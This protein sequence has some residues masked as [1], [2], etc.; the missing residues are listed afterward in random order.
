MGKFKKH[1]Y[2]T[3]P[4]IGLVVMLLG[5]GCASLSDDEYISELSKKTQPDSK[6]ELP[7]YVI[8]KREDMYNDHSKI[9]YSAD[10]GFA[11]LKSGNPE[12]ASEFLKKADNSIE[13][14]AKK[15]FSDFL[16]AFTVKDNSCQYVGSPFEQVQIPMY[17]SLAK[18]E[19]GDYE[20]AAAMARRTNIVVTD[21]LAKVADLYGMEVGDKKSPQ[22]EAMPWHYTR[23]AFADYIASISYRNINDT[24]N[25]L[26]A[27]RNSVDT[28]GSKVW[29][30][31]YKFT[32][33]PAAVVNNYCQLANEIDGGTVRAK[34]QQLVEKNCKSYTK[35]DKTKGEVVV[36]QFLGRPAFLRSIDFDI[37]GGAVMNT[38]I[39][40][41]ADSF[42]KA[43]SGK[44]DATK[45]QNLLVEILI[46]IYHSNPEIQRS[47]AVQ[48]AKIKADQFGNKSDKAATTA[49]AGIYSMAGAS[50][51]NALRMSV[52]IPFQYLQSLAPSKLTIN[53]SA[54]K[55]QIIHNT[56]EIRIQEGI[57][58]MEMA[59]I[60]SM[61]RALTQKL[62]AEGLKKVP[63]GATAG[64]AAGF[65]GKMS[66]ESD[67]RMLHLLPAQIYA[68][69]QF[70]APGKVSV[71]NGL[72]TK[73]VDVKPGKTAVVFFHE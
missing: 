3:V 9:L 30:T 17:R 20:T 57:D 13:D 23:D 44:G 6:K 41:A 10:L 5:T 1:H 34:D 49:V 31:D 52:P 37:D 18:L 64:L 14:E 4:A 16:L 46:K 71:K 56:D 69:S 66:E 55:G 73:T 67:T 72:E 28:Y 60:R 36:L 47:V 32:N 42:F 54:I 40:Q 43:Y 26:V 61:S 35:T 12:K 2:H 59:M 62:V 7:N 70:V 45:K 22:K 51:T 25:A 29:A 27:A 39:N 24:E 53:G 68:S 19:S 15:G 63:G 48:I 33:P 8:S 58:M 38:I 65:A 50:N 21:H 11:Y